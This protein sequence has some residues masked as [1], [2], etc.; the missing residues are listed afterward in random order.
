[1][2]EPCTPRMRQLQLLLEKEPADTFLLYGLALEYK[3]ADDPVH[4]IEYLD[5]VIGLDSGYCYAYHQKGLIYE[6]R[7]NLPAAR[8]AY[9]E[10]IE[11]SKKKGDNHARQE[12]EAALDLIA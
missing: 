1:M 4:A 10:G 11:A 2:S 9:L 7:D 5:R 3:K 12:I 6:S 8:S